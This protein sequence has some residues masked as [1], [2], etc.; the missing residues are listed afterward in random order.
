[1]TAGYEQGDLIAFRPSRIRALWAGGLVALTTVAIAAE[2]AV[3]LDGVARFE[4]VS[5]P[6]ARELRAWIASLTGAENAYM[7]LMVLSAIALLAWLSR[8][9]DNVPALGGGK[10]VI[11]PRGAIVWWFVPIAFLVQP[12]RIVADAWRRLGSRA[13][14]ASD[15]IV[16]A[17]W[18]L[19][20]GAGVASRLVTSTSP[21][22]MEELRSMIRGES[23]AL[24]G[25]IVAGILLMIVIWEIERRVAARAQALRDASHV[26]LPVVP[27]GAA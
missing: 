14:G 9:V 17:W 3:L 19:W 26:T 10:P 23:V 16:L 25:S 12:Y 20:L 1:M 24:S 7:A 11:G 5:T 15:L 2:V 6:D 4:Y 27:E 18:L 8:V 22:T 13:G 21:Q